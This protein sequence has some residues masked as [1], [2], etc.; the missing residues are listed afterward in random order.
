MS[1][2]A[3]HAIPGTVVLAANCLLEMS[4]KHGA[5]RI[6]DLHQVT[7]GSISYLE[8]ITAKLRVAGLVRSERGPGGGYRL[9]KP[10]AEVS[11]GDLFRALHITIGAPPTREGM[12]RLQTEV[13]NLMDRTMLADL[14]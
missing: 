3:W 7:G 5:T 14:A 9:A 1:S 10:A 12:R 2:R 8:Q 6:A 4:G 11:V 13:A